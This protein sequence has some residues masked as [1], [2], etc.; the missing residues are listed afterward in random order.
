MYKLEYLQFNNYLSDFLEYLRKYEELN[1][2]TVLLHKRIVVYFLNFIGE[3]KKENLYEITEQ[4]V[5]DFISSLKSFSHTTKIASC[6]TIRKFLDYH[7]KNSNVNFSGHKVFP[8]IHRNYDNH[9]ISYYTPEELSK[10]LSVF[11]LSNKYV[12]RDYVI[13]LLIIETGIRESDVVNL[14][15]NSVNWD[16][17][18]I[19][20]IQKKTGKLLRVTISDNLMYSLIN[21]LKI[22]NHPITNDDWIFHLVDDTMLMKWR[23]CLSEID[24]TLFYAE[25]IHWF[26]RFINLMICFGE[27]A[28]SISTKYKKFINLVSESMKELE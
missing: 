22:R 4:D 8:Y 13:T 16:Q 11:D 26:R 28:L 2:K 1:E 7:C 20:I 27:I 14:K 17:K 23:Q 10:V 25:K 9:I 5:V 19:D 12:L 15:I 18:C 3:M 6:Y 21:Y 24:D